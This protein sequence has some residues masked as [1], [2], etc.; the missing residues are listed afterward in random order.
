MLLLSFL[1]PLFKTKHHNM[2][3]FPI[4]LLL[5]LSAFTTKAQNPIAD[6]GT[7]I[8]YLEL[9]EQAMGGM[10]EEELAAWPKVLFIDLMVIPNA[11]IS[12]IAISIGSSKGSND[13]FYKEFS[14]GADG[15]FPDGTSYH[16]ND[17]HINIGTI[18]YGLH[19]RHVEVIALMNDGDQ[20]QPVR[21]TIN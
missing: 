1:F 13:M 9:D 18:P 14:Y 8:E 5:F 17:S 21:T 19:L 15:D 10:S 4:I 7:H 20:S 11:Q 2:K 12:A 16:T 3:F 6:I